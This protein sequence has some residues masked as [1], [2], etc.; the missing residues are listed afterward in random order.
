MGLGWALSL[1]V[2]VG[3]TAA[4]STDPEAAIRYAQNAFEYRDFP[5]VVEVLWPW[6]HPPRMQDEARLVRARELL[7]VSLHLVGRV[8]DAREEFTALL[9]RDPDHGLDPF[10]VPPDVIQSFETV[11]QQMEPTLRTLRERRPLEPPAAPIEPQ[12]RL[13]LVEVPHWSVTLLPF[14]APQFV[15]DRPAWGATLLS[16]QLAGLGLN[17][18]A[19]ARASD[20]PA[21]SAE[22][23]RW[24]TLQ[25]VGLGVAVAGYVSSVVHANNRLRTKREALLRRDRK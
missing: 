3:Q 18:A 6:L 2:C 22:F 21:D 23:D 13:E 16:V 4:P 11:K 20:L 14:G 1:A 9:L 10:T 7:G 15:L 19:F 8:E 17:L 12:V 24:V 25:Y 5:K